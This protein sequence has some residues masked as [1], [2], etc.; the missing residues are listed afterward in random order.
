MLPI[1]ITENSC[2]TCNG[3]GFVWRGRVK[4]HR[5]V[6]FRNGN[7]TVH[8]H[9]LRLRD[10]CPECHGTGVASPREIQHTPWLLAL[11]DMFR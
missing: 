3:A 2:P 9:V 5:I 11:R 4:Q 1:S 6:N 8:V 10:I 7:S